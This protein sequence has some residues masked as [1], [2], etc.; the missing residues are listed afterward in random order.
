MTLTPLLA[1]ISIFTDGACLGNPG[2]GGY[3]VV[4][5]D[6]DGRR[7]ELAA[8]Y[9]LT[10]NNRMELL[11]AIVGIEAL[12]D[13][14]PAALHS[15]S[16]Y[17]VKAVSL[18]WAKGWRARGWLNGQGKAMANPDLW[19][20]LLDRLARQPVTFHWV[21]GHVGHVENER[22][23]YLTVA[24]ARGANLLDDAGYAAPPGGRYST[25]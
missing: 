13:D 21:R 12:S 18:G 19:A 22:C 10:T 14:R 2:P 20:R 24:A 3:G 17:V 23:D 16:Q 1:P 9:R 11:A 4:I 6:H 7:R 25:R 8:G 15:D 5:L